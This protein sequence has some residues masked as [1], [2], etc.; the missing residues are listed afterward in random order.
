[1][2]VDTTVGEQ[3]LPALETV[4]NGD[5]HAGQAIRTTAT[6]WRGRTVIIAIAGRDM[7]QGITL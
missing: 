1:M 4:I 3:D 5:E 2:I 7:T 6:L